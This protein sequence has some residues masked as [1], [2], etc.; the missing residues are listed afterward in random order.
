M[1][2]HLPPLWKRPAGILREST[3]KGD[4]RTKVTVTYLNEKGTRMLAIHAYDDK[5]W[6]EKYTRAGEKVLEWKR[7]KEELKA[8]GVKG[9]TD[10]GLLDPSQIAV[11][12]E[13]SESN[14]DKPK[15]F[16]G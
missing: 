5:T 12:K 15:S 8:I 13:A 11:K 1:Q 7:E 3:D 6:K 2:V 9:R 10:D 4:M 16:E 14:A